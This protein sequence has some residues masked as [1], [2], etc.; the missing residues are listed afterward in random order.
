VENSEQEDENSANF[1]TLFAVFREV[2][3][4]KAQKLETGSER[5]LNRVHPS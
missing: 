4:I 1:P 3:A 5:I 2:K